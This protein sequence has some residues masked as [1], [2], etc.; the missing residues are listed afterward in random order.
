RAD[1]GGRRDRRPLDRPV[2]PDDFAGYPGPVRSPGVPGRDPPR[3]RGMPRERQGGR[4]RRARHRSVVRRTGRGL[5]HA[6]LHAGHLDLPPSPAPVLPG[7]PRANGPAEG[8]RLMDRLTAQVLRTGVEAPPPTTPLRAGPLELL[9]EAG[10]LRYV[11][12]GDR[13]VVRRIYV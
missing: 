13:E 1:R 6:G 7:H 11:R 10:D 4:P 9:Y 12:L 3:R 8:G 2:R 5:P